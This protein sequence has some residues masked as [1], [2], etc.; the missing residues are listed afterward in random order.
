[1]RGNALPNSTVVVR[2]ELLRAVGGLS[3]DPQLIGTEDFDAWLRLADRTNKFDRLAGCHGYYWAGG[4]NI[5]ARN[6]IAQ[7]A[8]YQYVYERHLGHLDAA[9]RPR[10]EGTLAYIRGR[11]FQSCR[12]WQDARKCF[13]AALRSDTLLHYRL[14]SLVWLSAIAWK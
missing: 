6:N 14:R 13:Q 3:E 11:V 4:G 9:E 1:V 7:A 5:G 2:A 8:R 12:Q 10:A